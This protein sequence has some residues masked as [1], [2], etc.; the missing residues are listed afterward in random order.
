MQTSM[1]AEQQAVWHV[2]I[3]AREHEVPPEHVAL[4]QL[5]DGGR[6]SPAVWAV[7]A[8]GARHQQK[9]A[10]RCGRAPRVRRRHET[11]PT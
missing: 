8:T 11:N 4:Q 3:I 1:T 5:T 7:K 2:A 9:L 6:A 10:V